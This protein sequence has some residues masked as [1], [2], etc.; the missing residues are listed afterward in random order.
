[1]SKVFHISFNGRFQH[2]QHTD[3]M[4]TFVLFPFSACFLN[5]Y[6]QL[7]RNCLNATSF[8]SPPSPHILLPRCPTD[9]SRTD[10]SS[11]ERTVASVGHLGLGEAPQGVSVLAPLPGIVGMSAVAPPKRCGCSCY[12]FAG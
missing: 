12:S 7:L 4:Q 3:F 1:M 2:T 5:L 11:L 9:G 10:P 6:L 8:P